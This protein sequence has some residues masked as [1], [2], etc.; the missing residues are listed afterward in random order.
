MVPTLLLLPLLLVFTACVRQPEMPP[1]PPVLEA[2]AVLPPA[3]QAPPEKLAPLLPVA[4]DSV[5]G[6]LDDDPL[7]A[8]QAFVQ[9]CSSLRFRPQWQTVCSEASL[10][11]AGDSATARHFFEERFIPH[12]VRK[13]D[14]SD[15]GMITGYYVPDLKGSRTPDARYR[16]PLFAVPDDLLVIDL[17]SVYPELGDYRL[18]GR[19]EGRRVVP[20]WNR[21][22]IANG[23][24]TLAGK[25]LFWVE[26]AVELFFLQIQG[27]GRIQLENGER[28]MVNFAEQNGH[29]YRSIGK[30][31]IDRGEMTS[32]QMSM[33]NIKAWAQKNPDRV[34]QLL[35][36][37]PSYVFFRELAADVQSPPGALGVPL[38]PG[39]S[40]AV[41][42]RTTPLGAPVF[43][44]TTWPNSPAPLNRLMLAQD[45]GGAIKGPVRADFFWGMGDQAGELAGRMKQDLRLWVLLPREAAQEMAAAKK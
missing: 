23:K 10:I 9:S 14:G 15:K 42:P 38:T 3:I 34:N 21:D 31:L 32:S 33:Q 17:R 18:R 26:D 27:S 6:W 29:P 7:P 36:E 43:I 45:T 1:Q 44:N 30:T 16:Y 39:R 2:P 8:L 35:N 25:E 37:N 5:T 19:I 13:P 41:D 28:V 20:Y 12:Q 40:I 24:T 11:A 4:W 22:D